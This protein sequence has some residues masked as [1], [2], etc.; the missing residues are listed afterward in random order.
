MCNFL[1][2]SFCKDHYQYFEQTNQF[3]TSET[4]KD[5]D[6]FYFLKYSFFLF[7]FQFIPLDCFEGQSADGSQ[8]FTG[9][10]ESPRFYN[11]FYYFNDPW[12]VDRDPHWL[13][14]LMCQKSLEKIWGILRFSEIS[15]WIYRCEQITAEFSQ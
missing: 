6:E 14:E 2:F 4:F 15:R 1:F 5:C 9:K 13:A 3:Y 7:P 11:D 12:Q 10:L 8:V